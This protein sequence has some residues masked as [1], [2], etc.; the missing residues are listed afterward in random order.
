[1]RGPK[2]PFCD[3]P[4]PGLLRHT[5]L[6]L[7]VA[8]AVLKSAE[9]GTSQRFLVSRNWA[10]TVFP[11]PVVGTY[12]YTP[13]KDHAP[14]PDGGRGMVNLKCWCSKPAFN[15]CLPQSLLRLSMYCVVKLVSTEGRN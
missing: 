12:V 10:S 7:S 13:L 3:S 4:R 15:V 8:A 2:L 1:M 14:R 9:K 6:I 5:M 11:P